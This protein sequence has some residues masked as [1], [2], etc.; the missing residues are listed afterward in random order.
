MAIHINII[1]FLVLVTFLQNTRQRVKR[2]I[3]TSQTECNGSKITKHHHDS[4]NRHCFKKSMV[5]N[6]RDN[7]V[8]I[9]GWVNLYSTASRIIE[10]FFQTHVRVVRITKDLRTTKKVTLKPYTGML[11]NDLP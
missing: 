5:S 1:I 4:E 6:A 10:R 7:L 9:T 3:N 8:N 2:Q 11:P